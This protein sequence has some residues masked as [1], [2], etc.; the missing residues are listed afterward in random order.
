[1]DELGLENVSLVHG[2]A[3]DIGRD[4]NHR[5]KYDLVTARAVARLNVLSEYCLPFVKPNG[6]MVALKGSSSLDEISESKRAL[7]LLKGKLIANLE[8]NLPASNEPRALTLI[9]KSWPNT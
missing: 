5:E 8:I 3:E 4:K 1:M 6:Y 9:E 2:R 7:D